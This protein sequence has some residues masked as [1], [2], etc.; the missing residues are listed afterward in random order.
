[1]GP[2]R[3]FLVSLLLDRKLF[4]P[5]LAELRER[6]L[7]FL[8]ERGRRG[9]DA[10][11]PDDFAHEFRLMAVQRCLKAAGTFSYQTAVANRGEMYEQYIRPMLQIVVQS[12]NWLD[13]FEAL[14]EALN[15]RINHGSLA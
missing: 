3:Y 1:M 9:L 5:S 11:D 14:Q 8:E 4:P 13:R 15:A 7:Y 10:I 6:R 12:A 2:A